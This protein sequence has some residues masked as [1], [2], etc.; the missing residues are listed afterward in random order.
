[1]VLKTDMITEI[2]EKLKNFF[3]NREEVQFAVIFG[4]LAKGTANKLSDV[5]IAVMI[6][7]HFKDTFPYGYQATLTADLMQE[8]KRNDV[9]VVILNKAPIALRYEVLRYGKFIHVRDKQARIQF[10]IDTINR[11]EDFKHIYR[12]HEE[13]FHRRWNNSVTSEMSQ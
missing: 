3:A 5:D 9:D 2:I 4:S 13:A 10:Q 12:V 11:Y 8:L 7:P 1:M 6:V